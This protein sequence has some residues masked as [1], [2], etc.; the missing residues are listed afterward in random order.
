MVETWRLLGSFR[1]NEM[2]LAVRAVR[3]LWFGQ[4]PRVVA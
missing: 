4:D 3:I 1:L 2:N